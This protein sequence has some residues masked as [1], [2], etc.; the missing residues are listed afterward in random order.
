MASYDTLLLR[1]ISFLDKSAIA[2]YFVVVCI[3]I[4]LKKWFGGSDRVVATVFKS[5]LKATGFDPHI[6]TSYLWVSMSKMPGSL[7][8][9]LW[10]CFLIH[11]INSNLR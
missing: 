10:T 2:T 9:P 11:L 4:K 3:F 1:P 6:S 8:A 5:Q 7:S